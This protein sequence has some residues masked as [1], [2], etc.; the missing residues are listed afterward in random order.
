MVTSRKAQELI[1]HEEFSRI[2]DYLGDQRRQQSNDSSRTDE[3]I[4][5]SLNSLNS[6][7]HAC[8]LINELVLYECLNEIS[9]RH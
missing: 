6:N 9:R 1:G 3:T 8:T 5:S 4:L 7:T 2:Y